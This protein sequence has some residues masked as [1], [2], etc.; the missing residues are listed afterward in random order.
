[1]L[2]K[3][4]VSKFKKSF[5]KHCLNLFQE[6]DEKQANIVTSS[7]LD[8]TKCILRQI[9]NIEKFSLNKPLIITHYIGPIRILNPGEL[10][11]IDCTCLFVYFPETQHSGGDGGEEDAL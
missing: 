5:F 9:F 11:V 7:S 8:F 6:L 10:L 3:L 2:E 1:M 4:D